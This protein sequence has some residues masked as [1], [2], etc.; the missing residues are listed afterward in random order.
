MFAAGDRSI[1]PASALQFLAST[2]LSREDAGMDSVT[3]FGLLYP[4]AE[5]PTTIDCIFVALEKSA[6]RTLSPL[7]SPADAICDA[8]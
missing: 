5:L 6:T 2:R 1:V 4:D 7:R 8:L 3:R